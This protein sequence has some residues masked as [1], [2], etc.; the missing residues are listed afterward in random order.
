M[1]NL[2]RPRLQPLRK[3]KEVGVAL[4]LSMFV[5]LAISLV[6]RPHICRAGA[7]E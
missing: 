2:M 1:E 5:L 3:K 4:L 6:A 7:A